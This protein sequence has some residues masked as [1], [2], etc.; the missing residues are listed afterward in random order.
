MDAGIT[1]KDLVALAQFRGAMRRFL[2][3]SEEKARSAGLTPQQHQMMLATRGLFP[4]RDWATPGEIAESLQ[5]NHNAAVGLVKR[6]VQAGLVIR[7]P[8]PHDRRSV[9]VSVTPKGEAILEALS[10]EHKKELERISAVMRRLVEI[11]Q[12]ERE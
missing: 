4:D 1:K 7:S 11:L 8:H 2:K 6:A 3:F 10:A 12:T 5:V 9:C